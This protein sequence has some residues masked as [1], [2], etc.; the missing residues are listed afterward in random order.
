[1]AIVVFKNSK[2]DQILKWSTGFGIQ[3]RGPE[4]TQR[5]IWCR[6]LVNFDPCCMVSVLQAL[7]FKILS[8]DK[9]LPTRKI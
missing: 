2:I 9:I 5:G 1:M 3:S 8:I 6:T 4:Q 7:S